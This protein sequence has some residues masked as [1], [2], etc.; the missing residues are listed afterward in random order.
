MAEDGAQVLDGIELVIGTLGGGVADRVSEG[1]EAMEQAVLWSDGGYG[2]SGVPEA[3][4]VG[5]NYSVGVAF[6]ECVALVV[7]ESRANVEPVTALEVPGA[8]C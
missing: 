1:V 4:G 7:G 2:H 8:P 6:E 3:N 5:N